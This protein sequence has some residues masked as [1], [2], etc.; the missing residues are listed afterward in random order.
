MADLIVCRAGASTLAEV[1]A[2]GLPAVL[3]PF[4]AATDRHQSKNALLLARRGAAI[5]REE[6]EWTPEALLVAVRGLLENEKLRQ[7]M[8]ERSR[9]LGRPDAGER[10]ARRMAEAMG[11]GRGLARTDGGGARGG[12]GDV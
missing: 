12:A 4:P 9:A 1:T 8:A 5:V 3:V 2:V 7:E 11:K 10:I 6:A